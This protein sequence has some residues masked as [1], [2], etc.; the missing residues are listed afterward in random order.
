[1]VV[2]GG[3]YYIYV[4]DNVSYVGKIFYPTADLSE[5]DGKTVYVKGYFLGNSTSGSTTY[6]NLALTDIMLPNSGGS[7]EDVIPD[8]DIVL[9]TR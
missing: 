4:N 2:N 9:P 3:N 8:D 6:L 1:M 5:F 7:T